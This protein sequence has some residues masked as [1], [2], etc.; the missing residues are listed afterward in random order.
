[1]SFRIVNIL[2]SISSQ[3]ES[4]SNTTNVVE[5]TDQELAQISGANGWSSYNAWNRW[6]NSCKR[7]ANNDY[8]WNNGRTHYTPRYR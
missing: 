8:K 5:L 1:M 7:Y 3:E 6:D 4:H 2:K